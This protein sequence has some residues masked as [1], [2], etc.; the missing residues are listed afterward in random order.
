M[1]HGLQVWRASVVVVQGLSCPMAC[2]ILLD[3]GSNLCPLHWEAD[4]YPL[5]HQ[6]SP[7]ARLFLIKATLQNRH[8]FPLASY[9]NSKIELIL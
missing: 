7:K 8:R 1:V 2:G 3:Q 5:Y 6:G 4:S 9:S